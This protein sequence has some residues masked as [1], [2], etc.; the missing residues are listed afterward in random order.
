MKTTMDDK[1]KITI[2]P[3]DNIESYALKAWVKDNN[4]GDIIVE[5]KKEKPFAGFKPKSTE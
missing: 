3:E 1:G 2:K 4:T 5:T